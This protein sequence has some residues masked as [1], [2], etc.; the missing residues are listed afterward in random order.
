[1]RLERD[2]TKT[3]RPATIPRAK[4]PLIARSAISKSLLLLLLF[5]EFPAL[6][7]LLLSFWFKPVKTFSSLA[8]LPEPVATFAGDVSGVAAAGAGSDKELTVAG[9]ALPET[10]GWRW[11][12][13]WVAGRVK[14]QRLRHSSVPTAMLLGIKAS[15]PAT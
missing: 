7:S 4:T 12:V 11:E 13:G 6:L 5:D 8:L 15:N 1:M 9:R 2:R 10:R 14:P 3:I